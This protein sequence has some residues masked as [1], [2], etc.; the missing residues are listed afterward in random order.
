MPGRRAI[1]ERVTPMP[2]EHRPPAFSR[3]MT[4]RASCFQDAGAE[5]FAQ[6]RYARPRRAVAPKK[7]TAFPLRRA[8][9][10]RDAASLR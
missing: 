3:R 5:G 10:E 1:D 8:N 2:P 7:R 6:P 4:R 9:I